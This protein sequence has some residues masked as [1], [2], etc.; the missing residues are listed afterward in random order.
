LC[1]TESA[2]AYSKKRP[3]G[4][5]SKDPKKKGTEVPRI[6]LMEEMEKLTGDRLVRSDWISVPLPSPKGDA[7]PEAKGQL[8]NLP[9]HFEKGEL[10]IDYVFPN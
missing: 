1:S 2:V 9:P 3:Y 8:K 4:T 7:S 5:I 6:T 10:Y